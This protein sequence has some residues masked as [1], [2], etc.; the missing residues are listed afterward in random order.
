MLNRRPDFVLIE[1]DVSLLS[2][3]QQCEMCGSET[4]TSLV[5]IDH[6]E[7]F[8]CPK[9]AKFGTPVVKRQQ[10]S[11]KPKYARYQPK[12]KVKTKPSPK[13]PPKKDFLHDKIL[14]DGYG[15]LII[16]ARRDRGL[17]RAE[18][19]QM[20]KEKETLLARIEAEK[21]IPTDRVVAKIERELDIE[22]KTE[23]IDEG[24][25]TDDLIPRATTIGSIAKIKRKQK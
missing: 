7:L 23:F 6:V 2:R 12:S 3:T 14:T 25:S 24:S 1:E 11:R 18:F 17:G 19:A 20:L 22:L 8:A 9:C 13:K 5:E 4:S 21:V 15:S 16:N 10:P